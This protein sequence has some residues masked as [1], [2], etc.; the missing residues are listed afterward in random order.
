MAKNTRG[1]TTSADEPSDDTLDLVGARGFKFLSA[2]GELRD[3]RALLEARGYTPAVHKRGWELI[4]ALSGRASLVPPAPSLDANAVKAHIRA[5]EAWAE[6]NIPILEVSLLDH[7]AQR[8]YLLPQRLRDRNGREDRVQTVSTLM[9]RI[10]RLDDDPARKATRRDDDAALE[11]L[12]ARG[13]DAAACEKVRASLAV[14]HQGVRDEQPSA[15]PSTSRAHKL[16]LYRWLTEWTTI[17]R[18]L[19]KN[20]SQLIRMGLAKP[21]RAKRPGVAKAPAAP[22]QPIDATG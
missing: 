15:A 20:R 14:I 7:T 1:T 17:T 12:T 3:V 5:V 13:I 16:A 2:L 19:V 9:T 18:T 10:A 8:D 4:D 6:V 21:S 22:A 11:I